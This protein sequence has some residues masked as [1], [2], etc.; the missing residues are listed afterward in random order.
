MQEDLVF[1]QPFVEHP[2]N[3]YSQPLEPMVREIYSD[4]RLRAEVL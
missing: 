1:T 2:N 4:D 3:R